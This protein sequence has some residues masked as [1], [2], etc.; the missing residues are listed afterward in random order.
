M[1]KDREYK[2][3]RKRI[4][5]LVEMYGLMEVEMELDIDIYG[6]RLV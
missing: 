5:E 4:L 1:T 3:I 6:I 2:Q